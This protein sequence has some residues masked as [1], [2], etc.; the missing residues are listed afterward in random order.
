L[1]DC[2]SNQAIAFN[3]LQNPE[4]ESLIREL[5]ALARRMRD[6]QKIQISVAELATEIMVKFLMF[7]PDV[8]D[9]L[10]GQMV[11]LSMKLVPHLTG[12]VH[13]QTN[14]YHSLSTEK[15]ILNAQRTYLPK[16]TTATFADRIQVL[17]TF[18][19]L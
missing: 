13:T 1:V 4:H 15:T 16:T 17:S 10:H 19:I 6:T 3:E 8:D 5:I 14:P 18:I 12:Y 9:Y 7:L 11:K 2:T